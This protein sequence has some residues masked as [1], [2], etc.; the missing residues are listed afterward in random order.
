MD[1]T[2]MHKW[3]DDVYVPW[4]TEIFGPNLV[5]LD[6]FTEQAMLDNII[7]IAE[8]QG[9]IGLLPAHSTSVLQVMDVGISKPFKN[10]LKN[11][12]DELRIDRIDNRNAKPQQWNVL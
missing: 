2:T 1:F 4:A 6:V 9:N 11:E 10:H 5:I 7:C 3:I 12:Y 8:Y